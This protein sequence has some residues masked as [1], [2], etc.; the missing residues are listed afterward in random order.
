MLGNLSLLTKL[1]DKS[2]LILLGQASS[3]SNFK[4]AQE[5]GRKLSQHFY[6]NVDIVVGLCWRGSS[7]LFLDSNYIH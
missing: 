7:L 2:S 1:Y 5:A 6:N 4:Q 3:R